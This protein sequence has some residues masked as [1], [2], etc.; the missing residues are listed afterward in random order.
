MA[1]AGPFGGNARAL[2]YDPSY[3]DHILLGSGGGAVF[4]S[5][6]NGMHW[7]PLAQLGSGHDLMLQSIV[8]DPSNPQTIYAAGWSITGSGGGFFVT[9][10]G[11]QSWSEPEALRGKS[12]QALAVAQ[13]PIRRR[14]WPGRWTDSS[15]A[16]T[17]A[18]AGSAS[19]RRAMPT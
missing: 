19:V 18:R 10:D 13:S 12:V 14:W 15:A 17:E 3:P 2:A 9:H 4:E 7:R 5:L 11:G 1:L 6:D 16:R 8:F